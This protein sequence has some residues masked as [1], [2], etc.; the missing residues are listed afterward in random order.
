[1]PTELISEKTFYTLGGAS[2]G[3]LLIC[4]VVNYV[5][6]DVSWLNYKMYRLIGLVLSEGFAILIMLKKKEHT[7]M[8]WL[9][10]ILNG[11]LIFVNASGLNVMTSSYIFNP[12]DST[13][14]GMTG[15]FHFQKFHADDI[16]QAGIFPLP[17]M[18]NWWPDEKLIE[19][20][21]ELGKINEILV[22]KNRELQMII[23]APGAGAADVKRNYITKIDSLNNVAQALGV[24]LA[25]KQNQLDEFTNKAN[26]HGNDLQQQLSDCIRRRN[27]AR[28]SLLSC[29]AALHERNDG[30]S[31]LSNALKTCN[32][33]KQSLMKDRDDCNRQKASLDKMVASLTERIKKSGTSPATLT[34][35][36]HIKQACNQKIIRPGPN[37]RKTA[38][39]ILKE[40]SFW[41]T[42]CASFNSWNNR[43]E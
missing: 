14:M 3:V 27:S 21:N 19:K 10:A 23:D 33:E 41:K 24:R 18:I 34:L 42:F 22:A 13:K 38:D 11:F 2:A 43:I 36:D 29:L 26:T 16:Q 39:D 4:W 20:N 32:S 28:D 12:K 9:F 35:T 5:A 25:E 8:K 17:R 31:K 1:M 15:Y 6:V 40:Q 30:D 7:S 37:N